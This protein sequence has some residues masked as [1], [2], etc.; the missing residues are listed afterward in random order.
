MDDIKGRVAL[1]TGGSRGIGRAIAL[2]LAKAGA[3][4]AVHYVAS[5]AGQIGLM[6]SYARRLA[7]DGITA[8]AIAPGRV[9]T[10]IVRQDTSALRATAPAPPVGR[11]GTVDEVAAVAVMLAQNGYI[12]GQ[13]I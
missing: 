8:N 6:H 3:D 11:I 7:G 9:D 1:V 13:T 4:V 12:T 5:K 2:A 10:D